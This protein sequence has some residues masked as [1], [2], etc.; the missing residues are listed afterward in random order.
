MDTMAHIGQTDDIVAVLLYSVEVSLIDIPRKIRLYRMSGASI[1]FDTVGSPRLTRSR[2]QQIKW[3][4]SA[5]TK[6]TAH[7]A[8]RLCKQNQQIIHLRRVA[9]IR[10]THLIFMM[11]MTTVTRMNYELHTEYMASR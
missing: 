11:R 8:A 9:V 4:N 7:I 5:H 1:W 2:Q 10:F 3:I 6:R